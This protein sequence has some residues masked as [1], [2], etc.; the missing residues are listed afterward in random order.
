MKKR[1]VSLMLVLVMALGLV[2]CGGN[3][4]EAS[5]ETTEATEESADAKT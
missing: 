2:A 1:I 3:S 5:E 4:E